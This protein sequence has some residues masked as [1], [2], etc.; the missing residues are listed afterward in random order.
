MVLLGG[1][2]HSISIE[3]K[4]ETPKHR[5]ILFNAQKKNVHWIEDQ[6]S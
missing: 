5:T 2:G 4:E 3:N 6:S 1:G